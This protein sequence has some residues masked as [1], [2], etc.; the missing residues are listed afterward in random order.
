MKSTQPRQIGEF[1]LRHEIVERHH[2]T[3]AGFK[4]PNQIAYPKV[5]MVCRQELGRWRAVKYF[6]TE[7]EARAWAE[8][9]GGDADG[10]A[11]AD[12]G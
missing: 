7:A 4:I 2:L 12:S 11:P 3:R 9:P 10:E 5:W 8:H 1:R 6:S